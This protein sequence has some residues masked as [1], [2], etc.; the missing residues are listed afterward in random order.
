MERNLPAAVTQCFSVVFLCTS[1]A[2]PNWITVHNGTVRNEED[3]KI[4]G[5]SY[6]VHL[7]GNLTD[8]AQLLTHS[9]IVLLVGMALC[10]YVA[11]LTGLSAFLIDFIG[12]KAFFKLTYKVPAVLHSATAILSA[13]AIVLCCSLFILIIHKL[14]DLK[15]TEMHAFF[16]ESFYFAIAAVCI[17]TTAAGLQICRSARHRTELYPEQHS[18]LAEETSHLLGEEGEDHGAVYT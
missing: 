17:S 15:Q 3:D 1:V 18:R 10:C 14:K 8:P 7:N 13:A 12:T 11:I 6:V 2:D 16:G 9:G 4:F 5:V